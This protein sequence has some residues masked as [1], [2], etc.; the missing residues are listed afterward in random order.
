[1]QA[2]IDPDTFLDALTP[3]ST[4]VDECKMHLTD[5][6]IEIRAVD[7][8]NVGMVDLDI[9]VRAFEK[10]DANG[11]TIGVNLNQLMD[12]VK[13]ISNQPMDEVMLTLALDDETRKLSLS[14]GAMEFK[15]ALIDPE[16]IRD[17]PDLPELDLP[18]EAVLEADWLTQGINAANM[19][20][21]HMTFG[22]NKDDRELY[23]RAEG[24]TDDWDLSLNDRDEGLIDISSGAAHS[25]F[26]VD[27][28]ND[29]KKAM[30]DDAEVTM[31]LGE[32]F[33]VKMFFSLADG[34]V[35]TQY[36]L[37][38]RVQSD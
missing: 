37:A 26:A 35:D 32:E 27:Y 28:L 17:E 14:G 15:L 10:Y 16:S 12:Q 6:G 22:V 9:G 21:D 23:M 2:R 11:S 30:P 34:H 4:L 38:P 7:P 25:V 3:V 1:M 13:S 8:A 18:A 20:S 29:M 5:D 24:D 31:Q 19:L 33:P 36:M